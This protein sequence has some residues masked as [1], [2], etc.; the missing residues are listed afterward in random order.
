MRKAA[1]GLALALAVSLSAGGRLRAQPPAEG[2]D[3]AGVLLRV[4]APTLAEPPIEGVRW[5][6]HDVPLDAPAA[7]AR[8]DALD[9][10]R[11]AY[12]SAAFL[13]CLARLRDPSLDLR[14]LTLASRHEAAATVAVLGAACLF[15]ADEPAGARA[16]IDRAL[17]YGLPVEGALS[18]APAPDVQ[19]F[20]EEARLASAEAPRHPVRI[21]SAPPD[22]RVEVDGRA[23]C[24]ATPCELDLRAG[25]HLLRLTRF[26]HL[27]RVLRPVVRG[28]LRLAPALDEAP[29][30]VL[31]EELA[32]RARR[33]LALTT[34]QL[35]ETLA[36]GFGGSLIALARGSEDGLAA[37][38][39]AD[40]GRIVARLEV[41]EEAELATAL[42]AA[43]ASWRDEVDPPL[44]RRGEFWAVLAAVAL[45]GAATAI[46]F[47]VQP[48]TRFVLDP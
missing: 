17:G 2:G 10:L 24:E 27:P 42:D 34:P 32:A 18:E 31:L 19:R 41:D 33:G 40:L 22:A 5:T 38:Y 1:G 7:P 13:R 46:A 37:V 26:G 9:A 21:R 39:D 12:R 11:A 28:P 16:L 43:L 6:V 35:F 20:L 14:A 44:W 8:L 23:A 47:S 25:E 29:A 30:E 15:K 45:T 4:D 36:E 3:V 48:P